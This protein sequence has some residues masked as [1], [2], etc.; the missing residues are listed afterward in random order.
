MAVYHAS[1]ARSIP[2]CAG[3]PL[4]E[5]HPDCALFLDYER[6]GKPYCGELAA[7]I[8]YAVADVWINAWRER[9]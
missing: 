4:C 3:E 5:E 7:R 9:E 2:T 6:N 8:P 1:G